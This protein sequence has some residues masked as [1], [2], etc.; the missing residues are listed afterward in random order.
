MQQ[1]SVHSFAAG[2]VARNSLERQAMEARTG[3][4][5]ERQED[6]SRMEG[7]PVSRAVPKYHILW[8]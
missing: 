6:P 4:V 3:G 5:T 2:F 7:S 1:T 8:I